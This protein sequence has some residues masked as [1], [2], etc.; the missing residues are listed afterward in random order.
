MSAG[1]VGLIVVEGEGKFDNLEA[2]RAVRQRGRAKSTF[3][4]IWEQAE[5]DG[6]LP[7]T[8]T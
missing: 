2:A 7:E 3:E 4:A 1:M 5:A 8:T 6:L